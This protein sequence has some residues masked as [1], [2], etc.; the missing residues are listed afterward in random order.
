MKKQELLYSGTLLFALLALVAIQ[1]SLLGQYGSLAGAA[2]GLIASLLL[3]SGLKLQGE[4]RAAYKESRAEAVRA[5]QKNWDERMDKLEIALNGLRDEV[6]RAVS[7]F[8]TENTDQL[9]TVRDLLTLLRQDNEQIIDRIK[10]L[11]GLMEDSSAKQRKESEAV[12]EILD[13]L[14]QTIHMDTKTMEERAGSISKQI[15]EVMLDNAESADK[16]TEK[17]LKAMT[18]ELKPVLE[19]AAGYVEDI[20]KCVRVVKQEIP[21]IGT[22]LEQIQEDAVRFHG[23][24]REE[25]GSVRDGL[26]SL[27]E[28]LSKLGPVISKQSETCLEIAGIY[29]EVTS[30]DRQMLQAILGGEI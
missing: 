2:S 25:T 12:Q 15:M 27:E 8:R 21:K 14:A 13:Q 23:Q 28:E 1:E 26:R 22:Q 3:W 24:M 10:E 30:E 16:A 6:I 19:N 7:E 20:A 17:H 11:N 29:R 4:E 9:Q 5:E 18:E